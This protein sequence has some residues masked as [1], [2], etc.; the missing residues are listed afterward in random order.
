L[1]WHIDWVRW[2]ASGVLRPV[3]HAAVAIL[4]SYY[5]GRTT[6]ERGNESSG[7]DNKCYTDEERNMERVGKYLASADGG[8][9]ES[10][11]P[12]DWERLTG[13]FTTNRRFEFSYSDA[14][15]RAWPETVT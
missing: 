10:T 9:I 2:L 11:A 8:L 14:L 4:I 12:A 3:G 1:D 13:S 7:Y 5:T 6:I 15:V